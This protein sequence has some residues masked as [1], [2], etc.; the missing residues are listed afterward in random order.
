MTEEDA[1]KLL[2]E[3]SHYCALKNIDREDNKFG[4]F[5]VAIQKIKNLIQRKDR[6]IDLMAKDLL[7]CGIDFINFGKATGDF[8]KNKEKLKELYAKE[9]E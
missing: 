9:V 8:T 1:I 2:E 3:L 6:Q 7:I 5:V 4:E